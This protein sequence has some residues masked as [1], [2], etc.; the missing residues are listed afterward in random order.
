MNLKRTLALLCCVLLAGCGAPEPDGMEPA[1]PV[2]SA[3]SASEEP[4]Q[5]AEDPV[6]T[7]QTMDELLAVVNAKHRAVKKPEIE[8]LDFIHPPSEDDFRIFDYGEPIP[9]DPQRV[10]TMEQVQ[11]DLDV[12]FRGLQTTYGPYY[13]FGGDEAFS[14]ARERIQ[15]ECE[16]MEPLTAAVFA[17]TLTDNL[18]FLKDGHFRVNGAGLSQVV[19]GYAYSGRD[20]LKTG[21]GFE[22]TD[23]R[24]VESVDGQADPE[25]FFR[26]SISEEGTVVWR[27]VAAREAP[28][29]LSAP[30]PDVTV[31]YSDGTVE[32]LSADPWESGYREGGEPVELHEN[33]GIPVLYAR[34]MGFDEAADD[35]LGKA[36][37]GYG[38][39]LRD[40]PAVIVDLRSNG[41]GNAFLPLKWFQAYAGRF[42]PTNY[43]AVKYW[44]E[45]DMTAYSLEK[46]NPYYTSY[47]TMTGLGGYTPVSEAYMETYGQPDDFVP[48]DR[49]LIVLT[50]KNTA[51]AAE[52][53]TD[54]ARN[55]ENT[56]VIG[57]NTF[58]CLVSNAYTVMY[59]PASGAAVQLGS[60]VSVFPE[61]DFVEFEGFQP[62]L[63]VNGDAEEAAVRLVKRLRE[64]G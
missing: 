62:D 40:A 2:S 23:G 15:E 37:L 60:D 24:L 18:K 64:K 38:E 41:G 17:K 7:P 54:M 53:F 63:W 56:L 31:R 42:V 51:S 43:V 33:Q 16:R 55:L 35:E 25:K 13:Y 14:K 61:N 9:F 29:D 19:I 34:N 1:A 59:L 10:M 49:L 22:T 46:E 45:A 5:P 4:P 36:F 57:Q 30:T 50:G 48:N 58:G 12:L 27:L 44:S 3:R 47:E 26:M 20:Y 28:E 52:T 6:F 39:K 11:G 21:R 8:V 32:T